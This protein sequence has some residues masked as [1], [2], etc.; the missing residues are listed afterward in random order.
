MLSG[1][2]TGAMTTERALNLP[3]DD[4]RRNNKEFQEPRLS[5]NLALV[6]KL[7]EI[8]SQHNVS[9]GAVAIAWTL[10]HPAVTGAI[11]GSRSAAQFEGIAGAASLKLSDAEYQEIIRFI[12]DEVI[13]P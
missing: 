13:I 9:P 6:E 4:W 3:P 12:Q 7:R 2:L 1:M 5:R 8:G 10:H 11:V